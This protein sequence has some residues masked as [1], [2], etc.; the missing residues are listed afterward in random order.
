V[1]I[2]AGL[3]DAGS[4]QVG[5]CVGT[6][7]DPGHELPVDVAVDVQVAVGERKDVL[8]IPRSA[9]RREGDRR[10]AYVLAGGRVQRREIGVGLI[11]LGDVEVTKGVSA[12]DRVIVESPVP[13]T[14][15]LRAH[16]GAA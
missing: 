2:G 1:E 8:T 14:E 11:G 13:L 10:V 15:G 6:I 4:R 7:A 12:G 9:L 5:E 16:A 3:R